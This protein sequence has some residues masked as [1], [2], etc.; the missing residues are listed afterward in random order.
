MDI[1]SGP[2][3]LLVTIRS[4]KTL[5]VARDPVVL[6]LPRLPGS[7]ACPSAAWDAYVAG[8]P[9][10]PMSPAFLLSTGRALT[11][12]VMVNMLKR[13][14]V[15]LG[16]PY[17]QSTSS[18]SLRRGGSL[19]ARAAGAAR[20]DIQKHGTWKSDSAMSAYVPRQSSTAVDTAMANLFGSPASN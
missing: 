18:H 8:V 16:C 13:A 20:E 4:T 12:R 3:G 6:A 19:A 5:K 15:V 17:A 2:S 1:V 14:L 10:L 11:T 9:G 7:Y